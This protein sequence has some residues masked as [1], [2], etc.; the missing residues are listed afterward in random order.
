[1]SAFLGPIHHWLY[2]KIEVEENILE[3]ILVSAK[4]KG[5]EVDN[6][7]YGERVVGNLEDIIDGG[8]IHGWLQAKIANVESRLANTVTAILEKNVMAMEEICGFFEKNAVAC[9]ESV[10]N[11]EFRPNDIFQEIY[12]FLLAGMPCDRVNEVVEDN[13]KLIK[14]ETAIDIHKDYWDG[15]S[16][17]VKNYHVFEEKWIKSF[18]NALA[19]EYKYSKNGNL[20]TIERI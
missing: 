2:N 3:D 10:A 11:K 18:V 8:N 5:F 19:C 15:V 4:S 9:A 6:T 16:G 12:N 1:M 17:D 13:E 14:W 7:N 20:N